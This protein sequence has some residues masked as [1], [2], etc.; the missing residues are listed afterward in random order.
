MFDYEV[1]SEQDALQ[2]RYQLLKEGMY[3]AV[4][5]KSED[6]IS[7][8]GNPMMDMILDVYDEHGKSHEVRDFLVFTKKTMW[9][10]I[11]CADSAGMLDEYNDKK[12]CSETITGRNVKVKIIIEKG[13]V[14]PDE[15]LNGKPF[16]SRYPD[17][18]KVDDY[19]TK[20]EPVNLME[21]VAEEPFNDDIP[22]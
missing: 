8:S 9:K 13:N 3:V 12:F 22:F 16:G 1:M 2:E 5:R 18:N 10:V 17:K 21:K 6:K 7:M 4:I 19:L 14:I 11:H 15:K 20:I